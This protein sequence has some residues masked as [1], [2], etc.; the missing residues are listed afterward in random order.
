MDLIIE[1]KEADLK[2]VTDTLLCT[3]HTAATVNNT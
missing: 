3:M 1:R 2:A